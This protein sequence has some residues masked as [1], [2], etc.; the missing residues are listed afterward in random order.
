M[1]ARV[2][3]GDNGDGV[4]MDEIGDLVEFHGPA[5]PL[6][7]A[8]PEEDRQIWL[9]VAVD[10]G[11]A[12]TTWGRRALGRQRRAAI[13]LRLG[14][15]ED[16]RFA[17]EVVEVTHAPATA[18]LGETVLFEIQVEITLTLEDLAFIEVWPGRRERPANAS[19]D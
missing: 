16:L 7:A 15:G 18:E 6:T 9:R 5:E 3:M 2:C 1:N 4:T 10:A 17:G 12:A 14:D 11:V 13:W 8:S 19:E